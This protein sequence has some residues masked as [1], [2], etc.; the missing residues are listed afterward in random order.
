MGQ[1]GLP[2]LAWQGPWSDSTNYATGDVVSQG[3]AS[4]VALQP[5]IGGSGPALDTTDWG[6]LTPA[7]ATGATGVVGATGPIGPVSGVPTGAV[8]AYFGSDVPAGWLV[9]DWSTIDATN[10][11]SYQALVTHLRALGA[12]YQAPSATG[13][14]LPDLRGPFLRGENETRSDGLGDPAGD[15][16]V[17][18]Y[19]GD[20]LQTH[21]HVDSGH[22]HTDSGHSHDVGW[23]GF[24]TGSSFTCSNILLTD[25]CTATLTSSSTAQANIQKGYASLGPPAAV[26]GG[27]TPSVG[28]ETRPRSVT[29]VYLMK[30]W[31]SRSCSIR[32][33]LLFVSRMRP[34][35]TAYPSPSPTSPSATSSARSSGRTPPGIRDASTTSWAER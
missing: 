18:T 4:Y 28:A 35:S 34:A 32:D 15:H 26:S 25:G 16:P 29:I 31:R 10:N 19:E 8:E 6:L 11:S 22:T 7:G 23:E 30:P 3:G 9:A 12:A 2:G 14:I 17:G 24:G 5:T 33:Q 13:A 21:T 27:A 20:E 1:T